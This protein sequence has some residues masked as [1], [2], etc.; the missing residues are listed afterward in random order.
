[1]TTTFASSLVSSPVFVSRHVTPRA[2][3]SAVSM[4]VTNAS[5]T[6][7]TALP[8]RA[9]FVGRQRHRHVRVVGG[10]LRGQVAR[11]AAR[12]V[13]ALEAEAAERA[14]ARLRVDE[15]VRVPGPP[16]V[17][18]RLEDRVLLRAVRVPRDVLAA[19]ERQAH[20]RRGLEESLLLRPHRGRLHRQRV[21]DPLVVGH[22]A[23]VA[24]RELVLAVVR[25]LVAPLVSAEHARRRARVVAVVV[26][27][28]PAHAADLPQERVL[29]QLAQPGRLRSV[30][31]PEAEVAVD[32]VVG[33]VL[34]VA[35]LLLGLRVAGARLE[36]QDVEPALRELLRDDGPAAARADHDHVTHAG[37]ACASSPS[38]C[39]R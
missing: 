22:E 27:R 25:G 28:R 23:A 2:S 24:E 31:R 1:M 6:S 14:A 8:P 37:D 12:L 26:E 11:R 21:L 3:P 17:A 10:P 32:G 33:V 38:L 13:A 29:R 9:P 5:A 7:V 20:L 35:P 4:L 36:H 19:L 34:E 16:G 30:R 18:L 15:L 39:P